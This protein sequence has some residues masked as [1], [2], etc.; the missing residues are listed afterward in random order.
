[1][2]EEMVQ[3]EDI[4]ESYRKEKNLEGS[5]EE[6]VREEALK[7]FFANIIKEEGKVIGKEEYEKR[8]ESFL[9]AWKQQ[10]ELQDILEAVQRYSKRN[11]KYGSCFIG[12]FAAFDEE[13]PD[14]KDIVKDGAS[15]LFAFGDKETLLI[16]LDELYTAIEDAADKDGFVNV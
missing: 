9:N 16:L 7:W 10:P 14:T 1:M 8:L 12:S 15:G 5:S 6:D 13:K 2:K 4:V 11:D 3:I